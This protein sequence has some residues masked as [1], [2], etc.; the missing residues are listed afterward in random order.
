MARPE[1]T[2]AL[3]GHEEDYPE[4]Q[5]DAMFARLSRAISFR[6]VDTVRDAGEFS[7]LHDHIRSSYPRLMEAA[8]FE[9]FGNNVLITLEGTDASLEP[10]IMIAH[11][12]VVPADDEGWTHPP[13]ECCDDDGYIWGR[14]SLDIKGMLFAELEAVEHLLAASGRPA[15]SIMLA[16][17][18]DEETV[19]AGADLLASVLASRGVHD[20]LLLDEGTTS[21]MD[22]AAFGAPGIRVQT[23]CLSQKGFLT[24]RLTAKGSGGHASNPFGGSSLEKLAEAVVA[25]RSSMPGPRFSP[26]L[27]QAVE[28]LGLEADDTLIASIASCREG[29]P[30][31]CETM[32]VTQVE[33]S[34]PA[35][36]ALPEDAAAIINFRLLPDTDIDTFISNV[37]EA[38]P[39]GVGLEVARLTPSARQD[40]PDGPLYGGIV[41]SF[42]RY[43][44]GITCIP[45]FMVGGCDAIRYEAVTA[46]S[47]RVLPYVAPPDD[48]ARIHGIDERIS[49]RSYLQSV[50]ALI[51]LIGSIC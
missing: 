30:F 43:Y 50:R 49:K 41:E 48:E 47:I 33:G 2:Y 1:E 11:Q 13:F 38:L 7:K 42:E 19:S 44:P 17:G 20:A 40:S 22:G 6:T 36:N 21:H 10:L 45:L 14:G 3:Y 25:V 51:R 15:R 18:D 16:F 37:E 9:L 12:D 8:S 39:E 35:S 32:A 31:A 24:L 4:L 46:Q 5:P 23:L 28:R 26:L 34:F 27:A 29:F